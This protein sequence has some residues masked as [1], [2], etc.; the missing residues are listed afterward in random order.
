[1]GLPIPQSLR[2]AGNVIDL[3]GTRY[4][5][6]NGATPNQPIAGPGW[7]ATGTSWFHND[8]AYLGGGG[9]QRPAP[10]RGQQQLTPSA[11]NKIAQTLAQ[12]QAVPV[13]VA[14]QQ[15]APRTAPAQTRTQ[16]RQSSPAASSGSTSGPTPGASSFTSRRSSD[17]NSL[18]NNPRVRAFLDTIAYAEGADY[19]VQ[20]GGGRFNDL[21]RHPDQVI[22]RNG[23]A[24]SAAGRYQFLSDT[25]EE[26][27]AADG[28]TD[29]SPESQDRGAVRLL[30]RRGALDDVLSGNF[31]QAV[32]DSAPEWASLPTRR[33]RSYYGQPVR[34]LNRLREVYQQNLQRYG[35]S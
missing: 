10:P 29:F 19:N 16:S 12:T 5:T 33:G 24:S 31:D 23:Y 28:L 26:V 9:T 22:R 34:N 35:G 17:P 18:V 14:P 2:R 32:F 6:G 3:G 21:S 1:M 25:W 15:A 20:F 8:A 4:G 7:T 27:A 11:R 13:S 30:R